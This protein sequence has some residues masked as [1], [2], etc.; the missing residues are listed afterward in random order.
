MG[1]LLKDD[2]LDLVF[3]NIRPKK[4]MNETHIGSGWAGW[5]VAVGFALVFDAGDIEHPAE[6]D[7]GRDRADHSHKD[8][9]DA[10]GKWSLVVIH[11]SEIGDNQ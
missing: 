11:C 8:P 5:I 10:K 1:K 6:Q 7:R 2:G 3:E 4:W 9:L